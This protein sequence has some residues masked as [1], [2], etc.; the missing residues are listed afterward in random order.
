[1]PFPFQTV[2][3]SF[4]YVANSNYNALQATLNWRA[5][6]GLTFMANYTFSR[7]I[8]DG[9][10]FR[11]GY[12]IPAAFIGTSAGAFQADRIE[13]TISTTN[14][15]QHLVVTGV[16][17]LPIGG[18]ILN[19][20]AYERAILGGFKF[21]EAL[22]SFSGSPLA[23]VGNSCGANPAQIT[24]MPTYNPAFSGPARINGKWGQGITAAN[25]SAISYIN[26]SAFLTTAAYQ[27]GNTARTAPYNLYGP[28]NY[29]LDLGLVRSFPL[30][31]TE[32]T[33]LELRAEMYNVTNHTW[34]GVASV[35]AGNGSF[36][37]ITTNT[38]YA[39][40]AVQLSGR[41]SF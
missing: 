18:S 33:K 38:N 12:P 32:A 37:Q 13:R 1:M 21:S 40:R 11:S 5:S 6:H 39:R 26:S 24:C 19:H 36:G 30:H 14:Q 29:Q 10:T 2:S 27:F 35:A 15:P 22:Q 7:S 17:N 3:D 41:L 20:Y 31:I 8:D 25:T 4:G 23:V 28:G 34:F 9:G 16:W